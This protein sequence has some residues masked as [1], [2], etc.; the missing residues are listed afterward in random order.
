MHCHVPHEIADADVLLVGNPNV[1]KSV[2]FYELTGKYATVSNYPGTTVDVEVGKIRDLDLKVVDTPGMYS[3][4]SITE[5]E[6]VAKRMILESGANLIIN[7]VDAKNLE[8]SLPLTLMLIES[9]K[10]IVLVLNAMDE[11]ERLGLK[12]D[13]KELEKRLGIP[14]IPT[15]AI[16][17]KGLDELKKKIAELSKAEQK[18]RIF[19]LGDQLEEKIKEIESKING[20]YA[21]SKRFLAILLLS[22]DKVAEEL[23]GVKGENLSYKIAMEYKKIADE[24]LDG[25]V[26]F[27]ETKRL[28]LDELTLNPIFAIPLTIFFL[29][30]LYLFAGVIGAQILVDAIEGYFEENINPAFNA[31]LESRIDNYW[32]RELFGGEYGIVTLGI[33]YAVAIVLPVVT[34]FF[35]AFSLLE[36]SGF[37]PRIAYTLDALFKK[38][39]LSGRAVIPLML[40]FGCGTMATIVTRVLESRKERMIATLL[41]AVTIPCSAQFGVILAI[42]PSFFGLLIWAATVFSVFMVVGFA[43]KSF[44]KSSPSFFMEIPPLRIPSLQNVVMKTL[45]RLRWYFFEV[46]PIFVAISVV[47]WI[48]RITGIFDMVLSL[49]AHP[50]SLIGLP[51]EASKVFLYGFFRRDYGA[52]GLYDLVDSG[53]ISFRQTIVAMVSLTLFVP[54]VAQFSVMMKERGVKFALSV[55][56]VAMTIAFSVGMLLNLLLQEVGI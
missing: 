55:F 34:M 32:I 20:E 3:F 21:V 46:L 49:L 25:I 52:A 56:L 30:I 44:F 22:G 41:L 14:V 16:K 33:R 9:C 28:K 42:A 45:T 4:F 5:E 1:G 23:T 54:C 47:I 27:E 6:V 24:I 17:R 18:K 8:R 15:V 35:I 40:G 38:I 29:Y 26:K 31:F 53:V 11:A 48:G 2:I 7:V 39:G 51:K 10:N 13:V 36:D 50:T 12:I 19:K 43:S 37:L